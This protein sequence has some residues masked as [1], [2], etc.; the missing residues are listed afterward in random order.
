MEPAGLPRRAGFHL[1]RLRRLGAYG[2]ATPSYCLVPVET[3]ADLPDADE[4]TR[5][6]LQGI[7]DENADHEQTYMHVR[8]VAI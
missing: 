3:F 2:E 5:E 8:T 4:E 1:L 6:R 7:I